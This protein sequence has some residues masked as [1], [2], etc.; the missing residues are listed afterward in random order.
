MFPAFL[1]HEKFLITRFL[2]SITVILRAAF[3]SKMQINLS[4]QQKHS[5]DKSLHF[6]LLTNV[7]FFISVEFRARDKWHIPVAVF[8]L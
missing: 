1:R 4:K 5:E 7:L 6:Y 3:F 8:T 2:R